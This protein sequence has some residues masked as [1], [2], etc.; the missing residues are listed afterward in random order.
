MTLLAPNNDAIDP[1]NLPQDE[2]ELETLLKYHA[3]AQRINASE[4]TDEYV[5]NST[6]GNSIRFNS[7]NDNSVSFDFFRS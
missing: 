6:A 1:A 4:I 3:V 2:V 7:Y 5:V